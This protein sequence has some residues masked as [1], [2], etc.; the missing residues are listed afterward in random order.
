MG[1]SGQHGRHGAGGL[2]PGW[3]ETD[4]RVVDADLAVKI[5]VVVAVLAVLWV[6]P[7]WGWYRERALR[8]GQALHLHEPTPPPPSGPPI[9]QIAAD[10]RRIRAQI[11]QAPPGIPV[12]R[13]RGWLEA[14]DDVLVTACHALDLEERIRAFPD[15]TRRNME[16]ERIERSLT[17]AGLRFGAKPSG[18][19]PA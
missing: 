10:L 16:R 4:H 9:E 1:R 15:G 18:S 6:L 13:L 11:D 5:G 8:V 17:R 7:D 12:A 3:A 2:D 19:P 14:Y